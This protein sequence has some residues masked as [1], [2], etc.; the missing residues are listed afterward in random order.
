M[1]RNVQGRRSLHEDVKTSVLF[2]CEIDIVCF[3]A[4]APDFVEMFAKQNLNKES[5]I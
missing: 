3:K 1:C 4:L 5:P 2:A